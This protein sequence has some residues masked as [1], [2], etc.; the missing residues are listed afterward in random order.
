M[1]VDRF[2]IATVTLVL[3]YLPTK[4][5]KEQTPGPELLDQ[6]VRAE[7]TWQASKTEAYEFRFE[8]ACNGLIPPPPPDMPRGMLIRVKDGA[9][10]YLR[11]GALP[12]PVAAELVQYGTV[13]KLFT[14]IRKAW[15]S[16]PVHM[17]VQYDQ[18]RGFPIRVCVDPT[19]V[20]DDEFGFLINDFRVLSNAGLPLA[21]GK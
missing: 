12:V 20:S 21:P 6:L 11:P 18:A 2:V 7:A 9:S 17:D 13:E 8:Y 15:T 19:T 16:R 3:A 4:L 10:T 1:L 14:F 5:P